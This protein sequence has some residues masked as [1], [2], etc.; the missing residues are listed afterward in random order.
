VP[1]TVE[2]GA[3][4][5]LSGTVS[6]A[7]TA[8]RAGIS[9]SSSAAPADWMNAVVSD[10]TW[11]A[12]LTPATAGTFYLWAEQQTN[13]AVSAVSGAV[14]VV[15]AS[16]TVSAPT[17]GT[18]GSAIAIS[19][20]VSP[21]ADAVNVQLAVQNSSVPTSGWTAASNAAGSFTGSLTATA[22]GTYY[23]W[24]QDPTTGLS[25]VSSAITVAA[26][27][28]L[29]YGINNPGGSY[30]HGVSTIP[31]NGAVNPP[32]NIATQVALSTSN[33]A[34]PTS[35]W[36]SASIIYA[37]ALWAV[38]FTTPAAAGNYYVWV[39]TATGTSATVSNFTI[40]VT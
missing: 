20:T 27:P 8:V 6:P 1:A 3:P 15:A 12:T 24:A 2:L 21:A 13:P 10:A 14:L 16:L 5:A 36:Q 25:A 28:A 7:N 39:E 18:A 33:T 29:T 40:P 9:S 19:G 32:Q 4:L 26:A 30:V 37:N 34:V 38:Y 17:T 31:L 22:S 35:G 23:A 11:S